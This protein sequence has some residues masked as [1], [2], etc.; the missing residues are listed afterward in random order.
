MR[1][2]AITPRY[3]LY[4]SPVHAQPV[5]SKPLTYPVYRRRIVVQ[6]RHYTDTE[7]VEAVGLALTV[8]SE[9]ASRRLGIPRRRISAWRAS[10]VYGEVIAREQAELGP[11]LKAA[12]DVALTSVLAG[13]EDPKSNLGHRARAL[14]VLT[15]SWQLVTGQATERTESMSYTVH[16]EAEAPVLNR[17][18]QSILE[19]YLAALERGSAVT[20][21]A[22]IDEEP[23]LLQAGDE[24][25]VG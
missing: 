11:R 2:T 23:L 1:P 7:K 20:Y 21:S 13:L 5:P 6:R 8:G 10:P 4:P 24:P 19:R 22:D 16:A 15:T 3:L 17:E 9:E 25:D 14:E 12:V 18:E